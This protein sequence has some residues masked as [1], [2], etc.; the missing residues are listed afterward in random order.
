MKFRGNAGLD[1]HGIDGRGKTCAGAV[2][3]EEGEK[4]QPIAKEK[5]RKMALRYRKEK[6]EKMEI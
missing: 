3:S 4:T 6:E 1:G 5:K 2:M